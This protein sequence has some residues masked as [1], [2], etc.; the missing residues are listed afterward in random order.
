M[1]PA[2][3]PDAARRHAGCSPQARRMQGASAHRAD[4]ERAR[5]SPRLQLSHHGYA[6]SRT[7][8]RAQDGKGNCIYEK[9]PHPPNDDCA[10]LVRGSGLLMNSRR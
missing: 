7:G 8:E 1:Q 6:L 3:A 4:R 9:D 10:I 5:G 2:G